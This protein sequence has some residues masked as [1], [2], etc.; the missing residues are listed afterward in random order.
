MTK[1][2]SQ[3]SQPAGNN[4]TSSA[5]QYANEV[6]AGT[7]PACQWVKLAC[8]RHL[9]DLTRSDTEQFPFLY[10]PAKADRACKFIEALPH[11]KGNWANRAERIKLQ[12]WQ[13]F[14]ICSL[15][16]WVTKD[17]GQYRF[18]E[19]YICVPRKNGKSVI[20]AG[21]GLFKFAAD[22]EFG[23]EVYSG[24]TSEKQ[25]WEV[26]LPAKLMAQR[27]PALLKAFG[28]EVNGKS[29]KSG[30]LTRPSDGSR[31]EPI[32]GKPGDGASPSCAIVMSITS[33]KT[34]RCTPR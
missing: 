5:L 31:F 25:A 15:F 17:S 33:T 30:S 27:T 24:A 18:R 9:K 6:L 4:Y 12:P 22:G 29:L 21:I 3:N 23:A 10:N 11:V 8:E 2:P 14:I 34:T 32:I 19:A 16:G 20:A 26:M 28:I 13:C 7:I 1:T